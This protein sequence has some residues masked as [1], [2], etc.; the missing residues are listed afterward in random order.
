[1]D[2]LNKTKAIIESFGLTLSDGEL[3]ACISQHAWKFDHIKNI[4]DFLTE[5]LKTVEHKLDNELNQAD[6][7][8]AFIFS[9][10]IHLHENKMGSI[11]IIRY[12]AQKYGIKNMFCGGDIPWAFGSKEKCIAEGILSFELLNH[13][14]DSIDFYYARGNHDFTIRTSWEVNEGYT[15]P[16]SKTRDIIMSYQSEKAQV[17]DGDAL[18]FYV[19]DIENK[20][21]YIVTDSCT[22]HHPTESTPWGTRPG[23]NEEQKAWLI[24][25]A[26]SFEDG[27]GWS[28][29]VFGHI[30]CVAGVASYC[31]ELDELA[32]ILKDFKN[33]RKGQNWDFSNVQAEFIA[34]I[35]GH[36]HKD[37]HTY[38]DNTLF[39][40]S[41]SSSPLSDDGMIRTR[42]DIAEELFDIFVI[43]KKNKAL[44]TVRFGVGESRKF[45][46]SRNENIG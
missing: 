36:N 8:A 17:P 15:M 19:D 31:S 12:L 7:G 18:Y 24:N 28:V 41:G 1:M 33:R 21:R 45:N 29:V 20:L 10:D 3:E 32:E 4:P 27:S 13:L 39:I 26:L 34:Y 30:S 40:S 2:I 46:Y 22:R 11:P 44:R 42:G 9:T 37:R 43:D 6:G 23:F 14:K 35:C 38:E 16:Y 5:H 25:D